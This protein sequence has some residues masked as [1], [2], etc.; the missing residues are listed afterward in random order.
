MEEKVQFRR[1]V[2]GQ[3]VI[4]GAFGLSSG[5]D[6]STQTD[7]SLESREKQLK[8]PS[9]AISK[10]QASLALNPAALFGAGPNKR[11]SAPPGSGQ[12]HGSG[13]GPSS[14]IAVSPKSSSTSIPSTR[15]ASD[16][17]SLL[18]NINKHRARLSTKRRLPSRHSLKSGAI[19]TTPLELED[20]ERRVDK[21]EGELDIQAEERSQLQ[22]SVSQ[23]SASVRGVSQHLE[24]KKELVGKKVQEEKA[25]EV[26]KGT[27]EMKDVQNEKTD[28]EPSIEDTNIETEKPERDLEDKDKDVAEEI[29]KEELNSGSETDE[30]SSNMENLMLL[31]EVKEKDSKEDNTEMAS[32]ATNDENETQVQEKGDAS[33]GSEEKVES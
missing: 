18:E 20:N 32:C 30:G 24:M 31:H 33:T 14:P 3:L 21:N 9:R 16:K 26:Q 19:N 27:E 22:E 13:S 10:L 28:Q 17:P 12:G 23:E 4:P 11:W 25:E 2:P 6:G 8:S 15:Y 29:V 5:V 7:S 1:K